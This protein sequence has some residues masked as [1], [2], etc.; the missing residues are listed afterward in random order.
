MKVAMKNPQ[1]GE[2]KEVK[3]G[4]SWIL[5]FFSGFFGLPLFLRKLNTWGCVFLCAFI[6]NIFLNILPFMVMESMETDAILTLLG[7]CSTVSLVVLCF[8]FGLAIYMGSKGNELTAKN[9]LKLGWVLAEP[10]S[11]DV[12]VAKSKWGLEAFEAS[13]HILNQGN[14]IQTKENYNIQ[15]LPN[16]II[17]GLAVIAMVLGGYFMFG[18]ADKPKPA[19]RSANRPRQTTGNTPARRAM[20]IYM[21]AIT[22]TYESSADKEGNYVHSAR[23]AIDGNV[24]SCWSEGAPGA[25]IGE[26]IRFQFDEAY[27]VKGFD[28][29]PGHQK[30][31]D[32]FYKNSRPKVLRVE[33]SNGASEEVYLSDTFGV[34]RVSLSKPMTTSF[35]SLSVVSVYPGNK[36]QDTSIAEINF[37]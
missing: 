30:S 20:A 9:Y 2:I 12:K 34:Q 16:K 17:A 5:F 31:Q 11:D 24:T 14:G 7:V 28:I 15:N 35:I 26:N 4:W 32:L 18:R 36:W 23:L 10:D 22:G 13:T 1:T 29:W 8:E 6:F 37:F 21:G 19:G 33:G 3:V 25:G 27:E